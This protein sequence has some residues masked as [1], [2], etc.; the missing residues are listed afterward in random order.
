MPN[1][2][3][4][5]SRPHQ[6]ATGRAVLFS[7]G[8]SDQRVFSAG[9]ARTSSLRRRTSPF[10]PCVTG[11]LGR[12]SRRAAPEKGFSTEIP[13]LG[14][15]AVPRLAC[16]M[17][18]FAGSRSLDER[19]RR[20]L[21]TGA[22]TVALETVA[23]PAPRRAAPAKVKQKRRSPSHF[24]LRKVI[25]ARYWKLAAIVLCAALA[26]APFWAAAGR[27]RIT[28]SSLVPASCCCSAWM[29]PGSCGDSPPSGCCWPASWPS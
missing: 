9:D 26:G 2:H 8:A 15:L 18:G 16:P 12:C 4:R 13:A 10:P 21:A 17:T 20:R 14:R 23:E 25:S 19:R 28:D 7:I 24:P 11:S 3:D 6:C 29:R 27:P 22:E 5:K 1:W